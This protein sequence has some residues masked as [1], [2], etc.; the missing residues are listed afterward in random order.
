MADTRLTSRECQLLPAQAHDTAQGRG[1]E[2]RS[3]NIASGKRL[4]GDRV[5]AHS[6]EILGQVARCLSRAIRDPESGVESTSVMSDTAFL[7]RL[8]QRRTHAT[9]VLD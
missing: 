4:R 3:N 5:A 7:C 8:D 6:D 9:L 1:D 2:T